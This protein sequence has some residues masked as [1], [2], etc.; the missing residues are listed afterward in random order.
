VQQN[1]RQASKTGKEK[2]MKITVRESE[3][4]GGEIIYRGSSLKQA[5]K[6]ARKECGSRWD[7]DCQCGG[8]RI[9]VVEGRKKYQLLDWQATPPFQPANEIKWMLI[10]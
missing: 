6:I 1:T 3:F 5:I 2:K 9:E 4:H 7:S 10:D 8:A